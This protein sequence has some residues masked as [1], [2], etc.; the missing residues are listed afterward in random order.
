MLFSSNPA[1]R[2]VRQ[3]PIGVGR[4]RRRTLLSWGPPAAETPASVESSHEPRG[5]PDRWFSSGAATRSAPTLATGRRG[6]AGVRY[7]LT[8]S[9]GWAK[10]AAASAIQQ[11]A[12]PQSMCARSPRA[13]S[14][15][16]AYA[17]VEMN[18]A[19]AEPALI[20]E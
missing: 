7:L 11:S 16:G 17:V 10:R 18:D 13:P 20:Q 9:A 6:K 3:P 12:D 15:S 8:R 14:R 4:R 1:G 2:L 5:R 19:A